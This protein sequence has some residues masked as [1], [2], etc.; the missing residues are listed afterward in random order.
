MTGTLVITLPSFIPLA[1]RI[2]ALL[3]A[4][5]REYSRDAFAEAF[6]GYRRIV[7]VMSVGIVVR[8]VAPLI[9]NKWEDPAVVAV[10]PDGA[11]AI[12]VIGGHHGANALARDLAPLGIR[13]VITTATEV[14]G[15]ESVEGIA[16]RSSCDILNRDSTRAVNAAML[17]AD[18]PLYTVPGPGIV[19]AGPNV[20]ILVRKGEYTVG[21]GCRK[22]ARAEEVERAIRDACADAAISPDQ[23]MVYATTEKKQGES[24]LVEAVAALSGN[25]VFVDDDTINAQPTGAPSAAVRLGLQGVAEPCALAVS[26]RRELVM[27]KRTYGRTTVA[28]AR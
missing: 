26:K 5:L 12:P 8:A 6:Q 27:E 14:F 3:S 17:A 20:S 21:I 22:G 11:Y 16:D 2:A 18:V 7:A 28:I 4:D 9:R 1:E 10:S 15:K 25:L 23:V 13:P 24:G 19:I